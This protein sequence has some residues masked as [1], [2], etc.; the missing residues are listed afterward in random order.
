[1][2]P[3][4]WISTL[5]LDLQ[6]QFNCY[7]AALR[8]LWGKPW[9]YGFYWWIW[10]SDPDAGGLNDTDFTPQNKPVEYL[11]RSWYSSKPQVE[12]EKE[13]KDLQSLYETQKNLLLAFILT[14][15][16]FFATTTIFLRK[17]RKL[18]AKDKET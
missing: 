10:E 18:L 13:Y 1:M 8:V 2:Q 12:L 16:A 4:N 3:W 5:E 17:Y 6:E 9:F 15:I 11:V 7:L 14:T